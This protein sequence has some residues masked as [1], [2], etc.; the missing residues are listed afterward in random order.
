MFP[1]SS[2]LAGSFWLEKENN[3][4]LNLEV[5]NLQQRHLQ[6]DGENLACIKFVVV[7]RHLH[8]VDFKLSILFQG[9]KML[10]SAS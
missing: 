2:L 1:N 6:E 9:E 8:L 7:K 5:F 3:Q 4:H 10:P